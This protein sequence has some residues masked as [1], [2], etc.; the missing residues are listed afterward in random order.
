MPALR[1]TYYT[2]EKRRSTTDTGDAIVNS[3][4]EPPNDLC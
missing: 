1:G 4:V 3:T 2:T